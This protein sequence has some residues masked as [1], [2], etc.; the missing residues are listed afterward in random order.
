MRAQTDQ[1]AE[2]R[3]GPEEADKQRMKAARNFVLSGKIRNSLSL[4]ILN[5]RW[6]TSTQ[7]RWVKFFDG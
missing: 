4:L 7:K 6:M 2:S 3:P 5:K 1:T